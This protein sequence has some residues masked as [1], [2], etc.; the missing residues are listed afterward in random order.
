MHIF[1]VLVLILCLFALC[2]VAEKSLGKAKK[3]EILN[4]ILYVTLVST[5]MRNLPPTP[6]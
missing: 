6:S 5:K 1:H 4:L 3:K 2:L